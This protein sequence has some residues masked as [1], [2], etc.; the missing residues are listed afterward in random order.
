[1]ATFR[2]KV[3]KFRA[4]DKKIAGVTRRNRKCGAGIMDADDRQVRVFTV[5]PS[6]H[7]RHSTNRISWS[8]TVVGNVQSHLT[9]SFADD[10]NASCYSVC[11]VPMVEWRLDCENC[12]HLTVVGLHDTGPSTYCIRRRFNESLYEGQYSLTPTNTLLIRINARWSVF[13]KYREI[14]LDKHL[15]MSLKRMVFNQ[16]VLPA[17][18]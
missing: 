2:E 4:S 17:M 5:Q 10:G 1:M 8:V 12:R 14:F 11:R 6:F 7:H 18:T 13:G 15:P 3:I 16:C 9:S